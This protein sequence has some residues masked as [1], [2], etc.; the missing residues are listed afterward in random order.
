M[1]CASRILSLAQARITARSN[2]LPLVHC[3]LPLGY[4]FV[5]LDCNPL[6]VEHLHEVPIELRTVHLKLGPFIGSPGGLRVDARL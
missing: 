3:L 1:C 4:L 5:P 2:G 6:L